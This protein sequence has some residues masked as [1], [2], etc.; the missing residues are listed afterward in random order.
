[1]RRRA[2]M[3][4]KRLLTLIII[5]IALVLSLYAVNDAFAAT[6]PTIGITG[7]PSGTVGIAYNYRITAAGTTP[8]TW[9]I[10]SGSLPPG[11]TLDSNTGTVSGTPMTASTYSFTI[12][13]TNSAG[14]DSRSL[15]IS[16]IY[17]SI[18]PKI[19]T[20]T[21]PSGT[22]GKAYSF[23]LTATGAMPITWSIIGS[24]PPGLALNSNTGLIYGT[25][26][27]ANTYSFT[28]R[29]TNSAG[30]DSKP[31][32]ISI[33]S[34]AVPPKIT[35]TTL[36]SGTVGKAYSFTLTATGTTPITWSIIG[37]LPPGLT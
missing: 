18:P 2:V 1:M 13:A 17:V 32:N 7:L 15:S 37:S 33:I 35:T 9:S 11:L 14:T 19:T 24:L 28:V 31:L 25:P 20:T 29:A 12:R 21:L 26:T 6:K 8:I 36:P 34:T 5:F 3:K 27:T 10:I 4:G 23:T 30:T 16:I 22:V